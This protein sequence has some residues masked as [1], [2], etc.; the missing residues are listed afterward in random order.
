MMYT[1]H[2]IN[3]GKYIGMFYPLANMD[4]LGISVVVKLEENIPL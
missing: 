1:E 2:G 3:Y 4:R